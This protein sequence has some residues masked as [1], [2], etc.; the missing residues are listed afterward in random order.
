MAPFMSLSHGGLQCICQSDAWYIHCKMHITP[1]YIVHY[2]E[3]IMSK[4]S[5]DHPLQVSATLDTAYGQL[6]CVCPK[7]KSCFDKSKQLDA[8]YREGYD[9]SRAIRC[10]VHGGI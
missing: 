8:V 5:P 6:R 9:K 10:G 2:T 1:V 4:K 7:L 3:V